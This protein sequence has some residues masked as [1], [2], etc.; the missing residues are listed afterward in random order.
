M[1]VAW[2]CMCFSKNYTHDI[3]SLIYYIIT[4]ALNAGVII[5]AIVG[6][7]RSSKFTSSFDGATCSSINFI[8]HTMNGEEK[9]DLLT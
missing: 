3:R 6:F 1:D 2:V 4:V 5:S 8:E 7:A 9:T